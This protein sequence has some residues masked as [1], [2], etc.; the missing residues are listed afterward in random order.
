[1]LEACSDP[2][3]ID[4]GPDADR[5]ILLHGRSEPELPVVVRAPAIDRAAADRARVPSARAQCGKSE[6]SDLKRRRLIRSRGADPDLSRAIRAPAQERAV[7]RAQT[8]SEVA[9]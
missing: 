2:D 8:A 7:S 5:R 9:S 4:R 1:M 6:R 3:P